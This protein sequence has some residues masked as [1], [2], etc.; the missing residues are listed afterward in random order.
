MSAFCPGPRGCSP[1][2]GD[3]QA[4]DFD[5]RLFRHFGLRREGAM[6]S[7]GL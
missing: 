4:G 7:E 1:T 5:M 3:E 2:A 6:C